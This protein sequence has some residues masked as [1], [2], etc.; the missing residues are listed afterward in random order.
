MAADIDQTDATILDLL[1]RDARMPQAAIAKVV[2]LSAASV[3]ER[4]RKLEQA[5]VIRGYTALVDPEQLGKPLTAFI[6]VT[7]GSNAQ[8]VYDADE[9]MRNLIDDPDVLEIHHVAGEDCYIMKVRTAHPRGLETL[10]A[11]LRAHVPV[12]RTVTM[13]V[14]ST[15][16][17]D[18]RLVFDT[19]GEA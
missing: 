18:Q 17:D 12:T 3:S 6:R 2:G 15:I 11:R 9:G 19:P 10:L 13:I 7:A 16:K 5:G 4:V 1:Q 8:G 14:L